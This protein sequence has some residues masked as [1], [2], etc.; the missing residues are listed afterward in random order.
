MTSW[1]DFWNRDPSIYVNDRHKLLHYRQVARDIAAL[2]DDPAAVVL[3]HGSGEALAADLVARAC[4][5][6]VLCD[7]AE[8]TRM[9]IAERFAGESR[10]RVVAPGALEDMADASFDLIVA[11][12][13]VQ[14][15]DETALNGALDLWHRLLKPGGRLIL[16]DV[17]PPGVSPVQD[18]A[19]LIRFAWNGGFL[20]AALAGLVRTFFSD[21]RK[22]RGELGFSTHG[23]E[24]LLLRL[25][26]HGF[27]ARRL[28]HNIGHNPNRM[29]FEA[30]PKPSGA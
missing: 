5:A 16:A 15:L 28:G 29:T 11:N 8:N 21:Y 26:Q 30:R 18:A 13:L 25:D 4:G 6:L 2:I 14:Y 17:I 24:T 3:D 27:D 20:T 7:A 1:V 9:R 10:I 12:S 23:A 22:L 19:A